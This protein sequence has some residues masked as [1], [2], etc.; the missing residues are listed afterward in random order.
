MNTQER[1]EEREQK[2]IKVSV[3]KIVQD[4]LLKG[5]TIDLEQVKTFKQSGKNET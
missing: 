2:Q 4:L 1:A 5:D 3:K